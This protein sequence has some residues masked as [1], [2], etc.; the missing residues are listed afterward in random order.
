M[1]ERLAYYHAAKKDGFENGIRTAI[2]GILASP[3]FLFRTD[4]MAAESG[5]G[6][7]STE[8]ASAA[9]SIYR[10]NDVELASKLA[11]FLWSSLPDEELLLV[12]EAGQLS[13]PDVLERQVR[14]MLAD[15][16]AETLAADFAY[17]WLH[18]NRIDAIRP[19]PA[20]FPQTAGRLDPRP[21]FLREIGLFVDSIFREDLSVLDLLRAKHTFVNE[22]LAWR[23]GIDGIRGNHFRRVELEDSARWGLLGKGALLLASSYPNRTSPV[24]RGE[25]VMRN[26]IGV[27]PAPPP[28]EVETDLDN[29]APEENLTV[30]ERLAIHRENPTCNGCH[31]LMDPLG[32]ALE[33][34]DVDG[35]WRDVDRESGKPIDASGQLPDGTEIGGPEALRAALL[36]HPEQFVQTFVEKL[37]AYSLG[38]STEWYDMPAVRKIVRESASDEYSFSAI[39]MG[40]VQSVPFTTRD[41]GENGSS[42]LSARSGD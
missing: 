25:Y 37:L 8:S 3:H 31:G 24:L 16:R 12:A 23:Y 22:T 6:D 30:R 39:V 42:E 32:F 35:T 15:A 1:E 13:D 18:L 10:L 36:E 5:A 14:R 17:Q 4:D 41:A 11:F 2:V 21:D 9:E 19:D 7:S 40:I 29:V 20:K 26:I 33:N 34:F 38:R 28:P 27:P